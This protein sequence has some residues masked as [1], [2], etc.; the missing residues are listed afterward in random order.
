MNDAD[1]NGL[2][3]VE[4]DLDCRNVQIIHCPIFETCSARAE[5]EAMAFICR[6]ADRRKRDGATGKPGSSQAV[7]CLTA[8]D[9]RADAGGIAEHFVEG[10]RHEIRSVAT[11]VQSIGRYESSRIE[12][13]VP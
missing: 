12:Q 8:D 3:P 4:A 13:G 9:Q 7:E 1:A 10:D 5:I 2:Q 11:E 6:G